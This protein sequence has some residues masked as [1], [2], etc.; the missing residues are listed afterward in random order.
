MRTLISYYQLDYSNLSESVQG[1]GFNISSKDN[2]N[3]AITSHFFE[4]NE[5]T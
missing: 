4:V 3:I 5:L 2:K 1:E